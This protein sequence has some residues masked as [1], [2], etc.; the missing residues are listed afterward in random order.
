MVPFEHTNVSK[1]CVVKMITSH[2]LCVCRF[3]DSGPSF[4]VI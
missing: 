3:G 2:D 4:S 1:S